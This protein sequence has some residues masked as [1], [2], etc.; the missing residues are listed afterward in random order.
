VD[1]AA[2]WLVSAENYSPTPTDIQTI[3]QALLLQLSGNVYATTLS[4]IFVRKY[5]C[6]PA[7]I[8]MNCHWR[9]LATG[10]QTALP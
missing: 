2:A 10:R 3:T 4:P 6:P 8:T 9:C 7:A 1:L 5:L